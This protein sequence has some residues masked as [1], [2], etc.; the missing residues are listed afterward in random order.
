MV[1]K[2]AHKGHGP[3]QL[4]VGQQEMIQLQEDMPRLAAGGGSMQVQGGSD[5]DGP[6]W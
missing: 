5:G 3:R 6:G 1:P 2:A 4:T